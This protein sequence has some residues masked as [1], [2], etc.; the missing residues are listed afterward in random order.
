MKILHQNNLKLPRK[1]FKTSFLIYYEKLQR[2]LF[3]GVIYQ[4][5]F[6]RP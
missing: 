5:D 6:N 4:H 3:N 1:N 2:Q